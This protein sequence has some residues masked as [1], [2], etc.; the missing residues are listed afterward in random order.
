MYYSKLLEPIFTKVVPFNVTTNI[1]KKFIVNVPNPGKQ[2][3]SI[4]V[5]NIQ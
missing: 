1:Q 5:I 2:L 3:D 4:L